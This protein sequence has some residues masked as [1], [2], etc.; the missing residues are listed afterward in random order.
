MPALQILQTIIVF[1]LVPAAGVY[2]YLRSLQKINR[3]VEDFAMEIHLL[4]V[5][6]NYGVLLLLFLTTIMW[7][8]S[9]M[10]SL[11]VFYLILIA[12]FMMLYIAYKGEKLKSESGYYMVV[13]KAGGYYI[14]IA[15]LILVLMSVL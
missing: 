11:G 9:G 2:L 8:W 10:S 4:V 12:P 1:L 13:A 7:G 15:P 3:E 14:V 6:A 5:F